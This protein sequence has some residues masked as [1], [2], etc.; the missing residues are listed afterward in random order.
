MMPQRVKLATLAAV[1]LHGS[2]ILKAQY[3][4]SFDAYNHMFFADHY[5]RDWWS[6][7][8]LKWYTGFDITSYPPLV[9]QIVALIGRL[10]GVDAAFGLVLWIVLSAYPLAVYSFS[11]IFTGRKAASYAA[12]G[13]ALLP[14]LYLSAHHF[15]QLPSL[16][17]TLFAIFGATALDRF[18]KG[19]EPIDGALAISLFATT[20][21]GHHATLLFT[22]LLAGLVLIFHWLRQRET[23]NVLVSR[24]AVFACLTAL[25]MLFVIWPFWEWG[26][27]EV[28]QVPI[29]HLSRHN[30]FA[31]PL[32]AVVY[33]L[34]MYGMFI[35]FIPLGLRLGLRKPYWGLGTAFLLLFLLGLGDTTP[36]P[37]FLFGNG[38][39]WLTYDRFAFWASILLLPF[40]GI[41]IAWLRGRESRRLAWPV[42]L[43]VTAITGLGIGS[44]SSWLPTQPKPVEMGP[45]LDYLAE[46][47]QARYRYVT[48]GFGDQLAYLSRLTGAATIDGSYHTARTLPELRTSG[49]GQIDTA[50]WTRGGMAALES[51]LRKMGERG[52]RWAF[53]NLNFYKP[54]LARHGWEKRTTLSNGIEVWEN[55]VARLPQPVER[56]SSPFAAFSW[57]VFPLAAFSISLGLAI[58][59]YWPAA[60]QTLLTGVKA[61]SIGLVPLGLNLWYYRPLFIIEHPRI[62]FAYSDALFFLSDALAAV[63][64]AAWSIGRLRPPGSRTSDRV[65]FR[66][67]AFFSSPGGWLFATCL[68]ASLSTIWS[69]D[70]RTSLYI[71]LHLWFCFVFYLV[72][73]DTPKAWLWFALGCCAAL[74][75]QF[76]AGVWQS[77]TQSTALTALPGLE[78]PGSLDASLSGA[79][80]VQLEDGTRWLRAYGLLPHPNVLG[81][82]VLAMLSAPLSLFLVRS[83]L[84]ALPL[85]LFSMAV[86]LIVLTFS[87]S[88][89][90]G[91]VFI[92]AGMLAQWKKLD[93]KKLRQLFLAGLFT[94]ALLL[95]FL[96][97]LFL[98]RL[99]AGEVQAEQVSSYTR[100]WLVQRTVEMFQ[101]NWL[102]GTG[103]GSYSLA[104][105]SHV[106]DFYDIEPVHS[107]PL[108]VASELGTSGIVLLGGWAV[109]LVWGWLRMQ[110]PLGIVFGAVLM[111]LAAVSLF[112]HYF[113]TL[114]PGRLLFATMLGLWSGQWKAQLMETD[115]RRG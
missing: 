30:Y 11:R 93:P 26:R 90:L 7:W 9:H 36:L 92:G 45:I 14:S 97:P 96:L 18:L 39:A 74:A 25:A 57:G 79:S 23:R 87:R 48:F 51:I 54:V 89:W 91:L 49:I 41:A 115:G 29:D 32:A 44:L 86:G 72:L 6:L 101:E 16:A 94:V 12:V 58:R 81:G 114:A 50:F 1:V 65:P 84:R 113:W 46:P 102:L 31:D 38:W 52:V 59:R 60:S 85:I 8:E 95:I 24:F 75:L 10:V 106:A 35:P 17:S 70:W 63:A 78:W 4:L 62:Y 2:L 40:S 99:G 3:R 64:I 5:L 34:P 69:L 19:G 56:E 109:V 83:K 22:P 27:R 28:M 20:V 71:S 107:L 103:I 98:T 77:V 100:L 43:L 66:L 88:A 108:L 37:R 55:P 105:S 47:E 111:G 42:L 33:F 82:F 61:V 110:R 112:D 68:L 15:G 76:T 67:K 21:A 13:A 104:L 53:V 80:I 73:R